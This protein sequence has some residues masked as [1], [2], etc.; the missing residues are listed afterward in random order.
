M[1]IL[2]TDENLPLVSIIIPVYNGA[3]YLGEA[4]ESALNQT[5]PNCEI[6]VVNDGS[7]DKG[8]TA[9]VA[10]SYGSKIHYFSKENGKVS[11]ALNLGIRKMKG[12]YFAWLSHDDIFYPDKIEKQIKILQETGVKIVAAACDFFWDDGRKIP[13]K[14]MEFYKKEFLESSVFPVIHGMIQ[15][16]GILL[17]RGIFEK[18]GM[19]RED[20]FTVQDYEFLF[21]ILKKEKCIFMDEIVNGV[22]CHPAQVGNLSKHMEK[23]RDEMYEMFLMELTPEEQDKIYGSPYNFFYQILVRIMPLPYT[24]KSFPACIEKLNQCIAESR[25]IKSND[26]IYIYG[27]GIYGRRLLFDLRCREIA[28]KG[29]LDKNETLRGH[30]IDGAMCHTLDEIP[31]LPDNTTIVIASEY[32]EEMAK[33]LQGMG[34]QNYIYKENYEQNYHMIQTAPPIETVMHWVD[35]YRANGWV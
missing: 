23:E 5:Y 19:F 31:S 34:I 4:I 32:R 14:I 13:F 12:E 20:L 8:K 1:K 6:I 2:Q 16:G 35:T 3:N 29:F 22:R 28:V 18:Y 21:R 11:T 10:F 27:A 15:F 26:S 17:H 25:V 33:T 24:P 30:L 7:T 9:Q